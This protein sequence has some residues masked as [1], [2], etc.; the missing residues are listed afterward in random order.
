MRAYSRK[1]PA[2]VLWPLFWIREVVAC[3]SFDC[4]DIE[5]LSMF[6]TVIFVEFMVY[7]FWDGVV[8]SLEK[9]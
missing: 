6:W 8:S 5:I 9:G 1:Q 7:W 4:T 3:E 2:L